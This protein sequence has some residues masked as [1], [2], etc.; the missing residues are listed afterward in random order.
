[1]E[2]ASDEGEDTEGDGEEDGD[3]VEETVG[4]QLSSS[5]RIWR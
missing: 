2:D 4:G 1:M 3:G 5:R